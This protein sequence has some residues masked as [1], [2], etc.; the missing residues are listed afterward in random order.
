MSN[1]EYLMALNSLGGRCYDDLMQYPVFPW[2]LREYESER[3]NLQVRPAAIHV[4]V[5]VAVHVAARRG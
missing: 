1:F 2:L 4:A 3:L 5:H